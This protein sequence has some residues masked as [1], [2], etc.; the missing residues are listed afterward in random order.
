M[1]LMVDSREKTLCFFEGQ[2]SDLVVVGMGGNLG[3]VRSHFRRAL[4]QLAKSYDL[5]SVSS[6]YR[7][8]PIGPEQPEFQNGAFLLSNVGDLNTLLSHLQRDL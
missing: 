2:L 5:V 1:V 4:E 3:A 6:L 7:S 8:A